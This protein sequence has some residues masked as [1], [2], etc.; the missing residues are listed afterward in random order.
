MNKKYIGLGL[1]TFIMLICIIV[2]VNVSAESGTDTVQEDYYVTHTIYF[3][4]GD[5][6]TISYTMRVTDGPSIDVFLLDSN[7]YK[8]FKDGQE[9][10]YYMAASDLNTKYSSNTI[11][12]T[13][14]DA[15]YLVFDNTDVAT[16]PHGTWKMILLMYRGL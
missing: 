11:T 16:D 9:F 6:I 13:E 7:N 12:F 14:H 10:E 5:S 4:S 3:S 2:P 1:V 8:Y 15:Y